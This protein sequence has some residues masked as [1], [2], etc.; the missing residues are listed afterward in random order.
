VLRL[1]VGRPRCRSLSPY[2]LGRAKPIRFYV[3]PN[4]VVLDLAVNSASWPGLGRLAREGQLDVS[5]RCLIG[6]AAIGTGVA[7]A[8]DS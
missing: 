1:A 6:R 4:G 5:N 3:T 7:Q 2:P 8:Q